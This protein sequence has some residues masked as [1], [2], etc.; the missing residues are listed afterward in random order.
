MD[1]DVCIHNGFT[2]QQRLQKLTPALCVYGRSNVSSA[3]APATCVC[4]LNSATFQTQWQPHPVS[5]HCAQNY[6]SGLHIAVCRPQATPSTLAFPCALPNAYRHTVTTHNRQAQQ[7]WLQKLTP[8]VCVYSRNNVKYY[9]PAT[10]VC[11]LSSGTFQTRW[12]PHI[13]RGRCTHSYGSRVYI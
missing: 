10:C 7:Q 3:T 2:Q 13:T 6:S 5:G 1:E 9:A 11:T 4:T 8:A 12:Q